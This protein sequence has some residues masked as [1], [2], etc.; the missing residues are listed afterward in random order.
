MITSIAQA[1]DLINERDLHIEELTKKLHSTERQLKM[2]QHQVEQL[3]RRIYGR[4]SEKLNP[5]QLMFD[6]LVLESIHQ[7]APPSAD[8]PVLKPAEKK[9]PSQFNTLRFRLSQS[10]SPE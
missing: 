6:G 1:N 4:R 2:L 10:K 9:Q 7:P 3:I 8:Q 5:N